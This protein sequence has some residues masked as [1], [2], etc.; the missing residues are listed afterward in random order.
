MT[1]PEIDG[2]ID[3]Q[4]FYKRYLD[5]MQVSGDDA[6]A[7]CPVHSGGKERNA[8]FSVNLKTGVYKCHGCE[9]KGNV[10]TF[11]AWAQGMTAEQAKK[12][13]LEMAGIVDMGTRKPAAR[14]KLSV[15][16]YARDKH[17]PEDWLRELGIKDVRGNTHIA[18][19]YIDVNGEIRCS[20]RR[21]AKSA[22][23]RFTWMPGAKGNIIPYGV[24]KL[25]DLAGQP[26]ILVEGE[27][28]CHALW[29]RGVDNVLGLPGAEMCKPEWVTDFLAAAPEILIHIEPGDSGAK[30]LRKTSQSIALANYTG[31]VKIFSTIGAKDPADLHRDKP[32][33]FDQ[34]W[35]KAL[36]SAEIVD[37][38]QFADAERDTGTILIPGM[39]TGLRCPEDYKV[40]PGS[41]ITRETFSR[42]GE[43]TTVKVC[44][45]PLTIS[46][47]LKS[48]DSGEEKVELEYQRDGATHK[49]TTKRSTAF[50]A[51]G[52]VE[53]ADRGLPVSSDRATE[54]VKYLDAL[55]AANLDTLPRVRSVERMGWVSSKQFLPG[56]CDDVILDPPDGSEY[57]ADAYHERGSLAAWIAAATPVRE[58]YPRARFMLASSFAAT[59]LR[60]LRQRVFIVHFW[61]KSRGGKTASMKLALSAWGEP[62]G[63]M[64]TFNT[65]AVGL[66]RLAGFYNDLPL[67][68][69]ERQV[70]SGSKGG[71]GFVE[72][73]VYMIGSG[74]G[75]V[76]GAKG[77][78][79]QNTQ[80]WR[81]IALTTGEQP[82]SGSASQ[83]GVNTR[84]LE[85]YGLPI[86]DEDLARG[87]HRTVG[88]NYGIAGP[89]FIRNYLAYQAVGGD[90]V[91]EYAEMVEAVA[92]LA[93][94]HMP[95]HHSAIACVALADVYLSR[96]LFGLVDS[97]HA[98]TEA[99]KMAEQI[100]GDVGT[101]DEADY[102]KR[103]IEWIEGW[104][105]R[106]RDRFVSDEC[107]EPWGFVEDGITWIEPANLEHAL[108]E[109]R[110]SSRRVIRDLAS[111]GR[112]VKD[113]DHSGKVRYRRRKTWQRNRVWM[114]GFK[115]D[116]APSSDPVGHKNE[117]RGPDEL[118]GF[119][120]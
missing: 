28:D 20:R 21:H 8:S 66:E 51:R 74:K 36:A 109:A 54:I 87:I 108:D 17:L 98:R 83:E 86:N 2:R 110:F 43:P 23:A 113:Y 30:M 64:A 42:Q 97:G 112:L 38:K 79:L 82:L 39:T 65:T 88:D 56:H 26:I 120:G 96:W 19:P 31:I 44:P 78:G 14:A 69:D 93:P 95:A 115:P 75:R 55:E 3:Y 9:A 46:R 104:L 76:R 7:R 34:L 71:Q 103:S 92:K 18:I 12:T 10:Y 84:S 72:S 100:L 116:M 45:V 63:L 90:V 105:A 52:I 111:C 29:H 101:A 1:N 59:M 25:R 53:L 48:I 91:A 117:S 27:S 85:I 33:D 102:T 67:G 16:D 77:G 13:V 58:Q 81:T 49:I 57:L 60:D 99:L 6:S 4:S 50:T 22:G 118:P 32:D 106:N 5:R 40:S 15:A 70:V 89:E 35:A 41:G 80:A 114:V 11:L 119:A 107:K 24:W 73:L 37:P 94:K 47:R 68:V 61:G 62:D